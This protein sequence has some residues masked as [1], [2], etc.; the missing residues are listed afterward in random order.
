MNREKLPARRHSET[1]D[2]VWERFDG[3]QIPMTVTYGRSEPNTPIKEVFINHGKEGKDLALILADAATIL[4]IALQRDATPAEL[5]KSIR[6]EPNGK[7]SSC[8]GYIITQ[9]AKAN[10][11]I[12]ED[13]RESA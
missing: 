7:P 8:I 6:R 5:L 3:M 2:Y 13:V 1:R 11:D 10:K 4:S 12:P 9:M